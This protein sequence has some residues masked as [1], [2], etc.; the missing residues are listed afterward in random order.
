VEIYPFVIQKIDELPEDCEDR[1]AIASDRV[2]RSLRAIV[3]DGATS[4]AFSGQWAELLVEAY[5][6]RPFL[7]WDDL[8]QRA[9]IAAKRWAED[10]FSEARAWHVL[11]RVEQGAA[12]AIAAIE[13]IESGCQ[14]IASA[15]GDSCVFHVRANRIIE[16]LPT[17]TAADFTDNPRLISTNMSRN[18][19][20]RSDYLIKDGTYLRGDKFVLATDAAAEA[21]LR[22]HEQPY[23]I[24]SWLSD[25][26]S[27]ESVARRLVNSLRDT[28]AMRNDDVAI[29][30]IV[31]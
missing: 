8:A 26:S 22:I 18:V 10:V 13:L 15:L 20:L 24:E 29:I 21:L 9:E 27:G 30:V 28:E 19:E 23:G 5:C 25:M 14:W 31:V 6:D 2:T 11:K 7:G 1:F 17:Y 4:T 16:M 12:A 3:A